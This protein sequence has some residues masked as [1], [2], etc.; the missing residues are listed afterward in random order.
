MDAGLP[1][2]AQANGPDVNGRSTP[3]SSRAHDDCS[4][5]APD[6][7]TGGSR[8]A[9]RLRGSA[10]RGTADRSRDLSD[11]GSCP[12]P[13]DQR[14]HGDAARR[15]LCGVLF[16]PPVSRSPLLEQ[17][18]RRNPG[19]NR[20]TCALDRCR[21][22]RGPTRLPL[23]TCGRAPQQLREEWRWPVR[24]VPTGPAWRCP[25]LIGW[26]PWRYPLYGRENSLS[27]SLRPFGFRACFR[28]TL[29]VFGPTVRVVAG[30]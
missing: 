10:F 18:L 28:A 13:S 16:T 8:S 24:S 12:G 29:R 25:G 20:W 26:C 7:R 4:T 17:G 5:S 2:R 22:R 1:V 9:V 27:G 14:F 15:I 30:R 3:P 6:T 21:R 23:T 11:S 19:V